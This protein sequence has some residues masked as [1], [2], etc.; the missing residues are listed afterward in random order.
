MH[1]NLYM[2]PINPMLWVKL[3]T[4]L[5]GITAQR[6][7]TQVSGDKPLSFLFPYWETADQ[8]GHL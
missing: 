5:A 3:F 1:Q 8:E 7:K 6:G 4:S 2:D